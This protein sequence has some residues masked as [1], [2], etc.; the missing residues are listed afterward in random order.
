MRYPLFDVKLVLS[1]TLLVAGL[2]GFTSI[3]YIA[4]VVGAGSL[5]GTGNHPN[6][7]LS[8]VTTAVVA[9]AFQPVRRALD[10][11]ANLLI[12]GRRVTP[13]DVLSGFATRVGAAESSPD[14]LLQLAELMAGGTGA[15][16]ARVWL[17]VSSRLRPAAT[18]PPA[19]AAGEGPW[20]VDVDD[21]AAETVLPDADLVVS[22]R[23]RGELLGALTISKARGDR[24]TE[25]DV[26]LLGRLA[27][28]SGV[29]LRN[30]RLDAELAQR[31]ADL[32]ASRR[33]VLS[34]QN[35]AQQRIEADLAGGTRAQ[36]DELRERLSRL[37]CDADPD[38]T[39]KTAVLLNQLV[40]ATDG[41]LD[42]LEGLAAGVYPPQLAGDGLT[43]ALTEQAAKAAVPTS[44]HATDVWRYPA[45][46]EA[47]VYFSVLEALQNV[48]KYSGAGSARV[49]LRQEDHQLRFE[50]ADDG[51]GFDATTSGM[52]TGL[53]GM[54]DRLD[55]VGGTVTVDSKPGMG[56]T[57]TGYVPAMLA[58]ATDAARPAPAG[59]TR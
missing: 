11:V 28:A 16:R 54:A 55:T 20:A 58:T 4:I 53:Q 26:D 34:A 46:V 18:W 17:R 13:Y 50:V 23:D 40:E 22:V 1:K 14:T 9:V 31:L 7:E 6:L 8:V 43:V 56:T 57:V 24:V 25:L 41:A 59:V 5:V 12:Y 39:P 2:A 33:R 42:T 19:L 21:E 30:L 51:V 32:E 44:V 48:A 37:V 10:R 52:G 3:A 47:A 15:D 36:L 29:V 35:D 27:A 45:E 38:A 49:L